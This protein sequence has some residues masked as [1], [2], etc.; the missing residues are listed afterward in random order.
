MLSLYIIVAATTSDT[1][2]N[3][4]LEFFFHLF[5]YCA[6]SSSIVGCVIRATE[7]ET[8]KVREIEG[9]RER[10][11]YKKRQPDFHQMFCST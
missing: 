1:N 6:I 9:E 8:Q 10:K 3:T 11:R 2:T 4:N 7:D 5:V